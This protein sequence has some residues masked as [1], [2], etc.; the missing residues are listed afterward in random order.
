M[1]GGEIAQLGE[2]GLNDRMVDQKD[3]L[4]LCGHHGI[5]ADLPANA[6]WAPA[7]LFQHPGLLGVVKHPAGFDDR[8][9]IAERLSGRSC[10]FLVLLMT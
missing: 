1:V 7:R 9:N 10:S 3:V 2:L 6:R 5:V 4:H 8:Q